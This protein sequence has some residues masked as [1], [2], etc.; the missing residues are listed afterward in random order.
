MIGKKN[1]IE[2]YLSNGRKNQR[3]DKTYEKEFICKL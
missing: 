1:H 2:F 3:K